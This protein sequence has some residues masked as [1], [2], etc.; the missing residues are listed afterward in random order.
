MARPPIQESATA[1]LSRLLTMVPW[2]VHRQGIDVVEAARGLDVSREQLE[3][4]L[5]LLFLC[6]Y[7]QLPDELI[8]ANWEEGRV[9]VSN[10]DTIARPLRLGV[11]EAVTLL[12]GLR[13]LREVPG[14][15]ERDAVDRAVAKLEA[16]AGA[17]LE[18][19]A[20]VSVT[21]GDADDLVLRQ[22]REAITSRR[23]VH[24]RYLVP[25]RD[26]AT[27]RDVDPMRVVGLDG[28]WYLEGWC[29]RAEDTRMFRLD[30][31]EELTVL[32]VDGTPPPQARER[33]LGAGSFQAGPDDLTITLRLAPRAT[34]VSDYYPVDSVTDL[35]A[36]E[37]GG[38]EVTLRA[39]DT[40]WLERLVRR[41]GGAVTVL[42]PPEVV[43]R[44][45]ATAADA[46]ALYG[47]A[48]SRLTGSDRTMDG[49]AHPTP[50]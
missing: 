23:R 30:R 4:D 22:A 39:G 26:E 16:A 7:G 3:S 25:A 1:R 29:H 45:R 14:L 8:D 17:A 44:V 41:H 18:P 40:A 42:D 35:P 34:W 49:G 48:Y 21:M 43:E 24:L 9:F 15:D 2:L 47:P 10:A 33:D 28:R 37:G 31:V 32:H 27:E 12:V 19:A 5:R 36:D 38:Q 50:A 46:L 20:R 11:D 13:A 6:G